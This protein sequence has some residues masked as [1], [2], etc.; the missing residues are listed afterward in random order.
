MRVGLLVLFASARVAVASP[1]VVPASVDFGPVDLH[2][3]PVT[4]TLT[5]T[6]TTGSGIDLGTATETGSTCFTFTP[7]P[8]IHLPAGESVTA[9]VAYM[10]TA[11]HVD[12]A[13]LTF[14]ILNQPS[15]TVD[16]QGRGIDRHLVV[17]APEDIAAFRNASSDV[18]IKIANTG[19]ASLAITSASLTGDPVWQ[20]IDAAPVDVPGGT[21]YDVHVRFTPEDVGAAPPGSV[22]L[23]SNGGTAS[24]QLVGEGLARDVTLGSDLD[25][26]YVGIGDVLEGDVTI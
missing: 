11:E 26:G 16:V 24:V 9:T 12:T 18:V 22:T 14:V 21:T 2:G 6:N 25:L 23:A 5:L 3:L 1:Q 19:E 4:R 20:L 13:T 8:A 15:I 17:M 7:P 10:P